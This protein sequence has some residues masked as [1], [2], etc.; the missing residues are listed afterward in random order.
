MKSIQPS[1]LNFVLD[2]GYGR[3]ANLSMEGLQCLGSNSLSTLALKTSNGMRMTMLISSAK[4]QDS[5]NSTLD[6]L[7]PNDPQ[8]KCLSMES[9]YLVFSIPKA[10]KARLSKDQQ[11]TI[12]LKLLILV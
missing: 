10:Q 1:V 3:V 12:L 7:P 8:S 6:S 9:L 11:S 5:M 4:L 2:D